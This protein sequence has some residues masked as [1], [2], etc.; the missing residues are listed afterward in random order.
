M[1]VVRAYQNMLFMCCRNGNDNDDDDDDN[2]NNM[3]TVSCFAL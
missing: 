3:K 2:G 1:A